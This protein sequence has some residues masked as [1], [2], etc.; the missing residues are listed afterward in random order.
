MTHFGGKRAPLLRPYLRLDRVDGTRQ[1][2]HQAGTAPGRSA[3]QSYGTFR[4][5][6]E[7]EADQ[8]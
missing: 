5:L 4:G 3:V 7:E 2:R 8:V 1:V 6:D